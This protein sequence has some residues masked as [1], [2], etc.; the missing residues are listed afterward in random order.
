MLLPKHVDELLKAG[1]KVTVEK[2]DTSFSFRKNFF[3]IKFKQIMLFI[4]MF[5]LF[6]RSFLTMFRCPQRCVPIEAYKGLDITIAEPGSWVDA[7]KG[8]I[9]INYTK[10]S[11]VVLVCVL[12]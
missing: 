5:I 6:F 1:F 8:T 11:F 12:D 4:L 10:F 2:Y 3:Q 7:P 9:V